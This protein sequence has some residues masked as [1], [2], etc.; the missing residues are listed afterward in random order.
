MD[1]AEYK[2]HFGAH[3]QSIRRSR[4]L[5]QEAVAESIGMDRVSIGYMEQGKRVPKISTLYALA[6]CYDIEMQDFFRF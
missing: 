6:Q 3:L 2:L 4:G 5:T 1:F